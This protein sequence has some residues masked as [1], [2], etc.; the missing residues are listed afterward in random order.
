MQGD[1]S[2][3]WPPGALHSAVLDLSRY[4]ITEQMTALSVYGKVSPRLFDLLV[5]QFGSVSELLLAEL[6]DLQ[7]VDG[8]AEPRAAVISQASLHLDDS[9][10]LIAALA[11]R[12]IR[13][14]HRL[15]E[16]F[17]FRLNEL[18]DPPLLLYCRGS[19]PQADEKLVSV[20]GPNP[21]SSEQMS[22]TASLVRQ[23]VARNVSL[24]GTVTDPVG[25]TVHLTSRSAGGRSFLF[26]DG[27]LD[28]LAG[29]GTRAVA[30]AITESGGVLSELLPESPTTPDS[31]LAANRLIAGGSQ[32]VIFSALGG[33]S[34]RLNDLVE[35]C[36][37]IGKL[38][39]L[40]GADE[41]SIDAEPE[42]LSEAMGLGVIPLYGTEGLDAIVRSLV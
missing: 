6:E 34:A 25:Q 12:D 36:N 18:N 24:I 20:V 39:F 42:Q 30:L 33:E 4:S 26:T 2:F 7:M 9:R 29:E 40:Y 38:A 13:I 31:I 41:Q 23:L 37:Q 35:A 3:L 27:G 8:L 16:Q 17:P 28:E 5:R 32:A 21:G 19:V 1:H 11:A 15:E 10:K 22:A 14:V